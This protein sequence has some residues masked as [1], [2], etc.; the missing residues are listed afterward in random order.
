MALFG[1]LA[2]PIVGA[3][4]AAT[5][6]GYY[7]AFFKY[8][9][10]LIFLIRSLSLF[11]PTIYNQLSG[12]IG[13]NIAKYISSEY[14]P[15]PSRKRFTI[16]FGPDGRLLRYDTISSLGR[17]ACLEAKERSLD[18]LGGMESV[19]TDGINIIQD[20]KDTS[21]SIM[22]QS[23]K[24]PGR[25][26]STTLLPTSSIA[27]SSDN[28]TTKSTP[29]NIL[30][31]LSFWKT[32]SKSNLGHKNSPQ[33]Y[34]KFDEDPTQEYPETY[35]YTCNFIRNH[36]I[37]SRL[38]HLVVISTLRVVLIEC[39][40]DTSEEGVDFKE[41]WAVNNLNIYY[42]PFNLFNCYVILLPFIIIL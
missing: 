31:Y 33:N 20:I 1:V 7:F 36:T 22:N 19:I 11:F 41:L 26:Y 6:A 4:D 40:Q 29:P 30:S 3:L 9:Y 15:P 2:K 37:H 24:I 13:Q 17:Y 28:S 16:L 39:K 21:K 38:T 10:F 5:H 32:D 12:E 25:G 34:E 14:F 42:I 27:S 35:I 23:I 18:A 8:I